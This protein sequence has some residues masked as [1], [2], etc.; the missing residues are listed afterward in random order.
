MLQSVYEHGGFWIGRYEAGTTTARNKGNSAS[1]IVPLSKIDLYPINWVKCSEAQTIA[2]SAQ[3][4][5]RTKYTSGLMFG[6]QWDLVLRHLSNKGLETSKITGNSETWG[7]YNLAY[8][9]D[10]TSVH[11]YKGERKN[12]SPYNLTWSAIESGYSHRKYSSK[13]IP[14]TALSTGATTRNMKSNIY[15]LAGNMDEWTLEKSSYSSRPCASRG[16]VFGNAGS[17]YPASYRRYSLTSNSSSA[18]RSS[19]HTLLE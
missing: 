5:D 13:S 15:D 2:G 11:G 16:G 4:I 9:L 7:N 1:E 12:S 10:Q 3:N 18:D 8:D 17:F 6:I 14:Y 19:C